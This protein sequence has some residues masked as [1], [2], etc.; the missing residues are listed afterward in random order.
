MFEELD[1]QNGYL[2]FQGGYYLNR[3][4]LSIIFGVSSH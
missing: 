1:E 4:Q 3:Q 2:L